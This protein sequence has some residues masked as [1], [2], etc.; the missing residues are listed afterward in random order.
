MARFARPAIPYSDVAFRNYILTSKQNES[1]TKRDWDRSTGHDAR[2]V[3]G[4]ANMRDEWISIEA[5]T[6]ILGVTRYSV[7]VM[8]DKGLLTNRVIPGCHIKISRAHAEEIARQAVR[9][10]SGRVACGAL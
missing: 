8:I 2:H 10:A 6:Q 1:T 3:A 4:V 5:A 7:R 9:P